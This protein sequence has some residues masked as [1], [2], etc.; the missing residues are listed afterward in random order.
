[1]QSSFTL[2]FHSLCVK[3]ARTSIALSGDE[4]VQVAILWVLI[5]EA[6][7]EL[8]HVVSHLHLVERPDAACVLIRESR[9]RRLVNPDY[10]RVG[11]PAVRIQRQRQII[12]DVIRALKSKNKQRRRPIMSELVCAVRAPVKQDQLVSIFCAVKAP[13]VCFRLLRTDIL[14]EQS[15]ES[16][17]AG[18][19]SHPEHQGVAGGIIATFEAPIPQVSLQSWSGAIHGDIARPVLTSNK[20]AAMSRGQRQSALRA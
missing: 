14:L 9:S 17:A 16:A 3:E 19:A 6:L 20:A 2:G 15:H 18:S 1:M 12:G 13:A 10:C 4:E 5:E 7:E 8:V 11:I